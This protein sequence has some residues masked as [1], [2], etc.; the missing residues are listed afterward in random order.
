MYSSREQEASS[1]TSQCFDHSISDDDDVVDPH[2]P[3]MQSRHSSPDS[4]ASPHRE[5]ASRHEQQE[6]NM[7][8]KSMTSSLSSSTFSSAASKRDSLYSLA[9]SSTVASSINE[10]AA[11]GNFDME[12]KKRWSASSLTSLDDITSEYK[13]SGY[14]ITG[15]ES[16]SI[17][18]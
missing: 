13:G 7:L 4:L 18:G 8:D 11:V 10:Q 15:K 5:A 14:F 16:D 12:N 1:Q 17:I 2:R 6:N 3:E 9:R